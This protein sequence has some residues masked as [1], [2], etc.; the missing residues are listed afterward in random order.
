[1]ASPPGLI[2]TVET[3]K[4]SNYDELVKMTPARRAGTVAEVAA[5]VGYLAS[6]KSGFIS[7]Q[8]ISIDGGCS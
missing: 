2:D 6:D 8:Q 3:T 1:V 5:L 4:L 7:G